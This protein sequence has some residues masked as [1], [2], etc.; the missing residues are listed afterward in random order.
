MKKSI[1]RL[2]IILTVGIIGMTSA[3]AATCCLTDDDRPIKYDELPAETKS[4]VSKH[5]AKEEVSHTSLDNDLINKEYTVV[6]LSG[7][8]VEFDGN[9]EWKEVDCRYSQVPTAIIPEAIAAYVKEHYPNSKI[10]ELKRE[11]SNW[12]AKI[13]GGL[14]LTFNNNFKLVDIDD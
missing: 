5:F 2:A 3:I 4:F 12:E 6:F 10:T 7:T 1:K 13:T 9:G 8:K 14:E 11:H